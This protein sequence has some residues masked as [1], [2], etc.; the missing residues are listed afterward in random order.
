[1]STPTPAGEMVPIG[2]D[3]AGIRRHATRFTNTANA[4][5]DAVR[6]LQTVRDASEEQQS[7]AVEALAGAIGDTRNRLNQL[8][9]RYE[10]AGSQ[11][12]EF[13]EVLESAQGRANTAITS[14]GAAQSTAR[15]YE[16]R[17]AEATE[18]RSA[19]VDPAELQTATDAVTRYNTALSNARGDALQARTA[20]A[21][22]V[23][24]V[25]E[26]GNSA[27]SAI[28]RA[29]EGDDL[30]DSWWDNVMDWVNDNAGWLKVVKDILTVV[31]TII[32]VLSIFFPV[33]APLALGLAVLTAGLSFLLAAS[34]SGSWIDFALDMVGVLTLGVGSAALAGIKTRLGGPARQP[35]RAPRPDPPGDG[36]RQHPAAGRRQPLPARPGRLDAAAVPDGRA[37]SRIGASRAPGA[38]AGRHEADLAVD[39]DDPGG[40]QRHHR[41][42]QPGRLPG[43]AGCR[44]LHRRRDHRR[45]RPPQQRVQHQLEH[46]RR[47]STP[48]TTPAWASTTVIS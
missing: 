16:Y 40:R 38:A 46:Q 39:D 43:A 21:Q 17:V 42:V 22:A 25:E 45:G 37:R 36:V 24:D 5:R 33:L 7:D 48:S 15:G 44:R 2:G 10:V 27:A 18:T 12:T 23:A 3:V 13:A 11:L 26:A 8:R 20:H 4:I 30:N 14:Y 35:R 31:T 1:M 6:L 19:T 9:D 32:G 34:G 29:V 41:R 47:A 28:S